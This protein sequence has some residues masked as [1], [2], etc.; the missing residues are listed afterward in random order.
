M[1]KGEV[2]P[3]VVI[4]TVVII[5]LVLVVVIPFFASTPIKQSRDI[6]KTLGLGE[7]TT[8]QDNKDVLS[9]KEF[10]SKLRD[11]SKYSQDNCLC[12]APFNKFT[13]KHLLTFS[14]KDIKIESVNAQNKVT[15][16]KEDINNAAC[17]FSD[18][19]FFPVDFLSIN[20]DGNGAY[21]DSGS[22]FRSNI[23]LLNKDNVYKKRENLCF[24]AEGSTNLPEKCGK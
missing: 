6:I 16:L 17:Y 4:V 5:L 13:N 15:L 10:Y 1:D 11:C 24:I 14:R 9:V 22:I 23:R 12:D 2:K 19:T 21:I 7:E 18:G 20:F 3:V 8:D